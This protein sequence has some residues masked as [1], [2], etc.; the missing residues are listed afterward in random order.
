MAKARTTKAK[1]AKAKTPQELQAA[2]R[3]KMKKNQKAKAA[4]KAPAK[5][6]RAKKV[7]KTVIGKG[8]VPVG[9]P[10]TLTLEIVEALCT[11][12]RDGGFIQTALAGEGIGHSTYY[13]WI[14][15]GERDKF[16]GNESIYTQF[17]DMIKKAETVAEMASIQ[18]IQEGGLGWQGSA[19]FAERRFP[20][21]WGNR[22]RLTMEEAQNFGRKMLAVLAEEIPDRAVLE[23]IVIKIRQIEGEQHDLVARGA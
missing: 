18:R 16:A 12:L 22:M 1:T 3:R 20:S 9:H 6:T 4:K 23:R 21:R 14:D 11:Y 13:T 2:S 15:L 5:K 7:G 10:T 17:M 19:W 8:L